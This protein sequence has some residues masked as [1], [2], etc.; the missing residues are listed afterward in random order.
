MNYFS[1]Y[2]VD[3]KEGRYAYNTGLLLP[4]ITRKQVAKFTLKESYT[5]LQQQFYEGCEAH[6][7][8]DKY[9]HSSPFFKM[10][11]DHSNR[12]INESP[13]S[14]SVQRKWFLAHILG[15][16]M[17]DR[18]LVK[19]YPEQ[20]EGFYDSLNRADDN[21]LADFL[22]LNGMEKIEVFFDFFNHFRKVQYIYYY[23]DNNKFVYSLNRIMI[24]AGVGALTESDQDVLLNTTLKL[25]EV[26][27]ADVMTLVE[28]LIESKQK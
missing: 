15:E 13:F 26:L 23:A 3:H 20:L 1:H 14:D 11:L 8:G 10:V 6:Y 27:S 9:F 2:F 17:I 19:N 4:D 12:L 7:R 25:E 24:Q 21:E 18:I 22:R 16:L 5:P 28:Q